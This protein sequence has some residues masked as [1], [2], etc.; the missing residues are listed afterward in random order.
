MPSEGADIGERRPMPEDWD[1]GIVFGEMRGTKV[2]L[3]APPG[4]GSGNFLSYLVS[5]DPEREEFLY[6]SLRL[7]AWTVLEERRLAGLG[8]SPIC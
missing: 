6:R 2:A 8:A 1:A 5:D 7:M 4:D 3:W